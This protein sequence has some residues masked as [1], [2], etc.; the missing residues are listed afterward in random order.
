MGI[1]DLTRE[2]IERERVEEA[3]D[4]LSYPVRLSFDERG[5]V[6]VALSLSV[7][8]LSHYEERRASKKKEGR[9]D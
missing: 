6:H 8:D 5:E 3:A 4:W 1:D 2:R 7:G 9:R